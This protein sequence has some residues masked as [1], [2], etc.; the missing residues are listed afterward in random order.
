MQNS[1]KSAD[2]PRIPP[3]PRWARDR[4]VALSD[5]RIDGLRELPVR[6]IGDPEALRVSSEGG[7]EDLGP[8]VDQVP[9]ATVALALEG[10]ARGV[11]E[12]RGDS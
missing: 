7:P 9:M 6:I 8:A 2:E 5:R 12:A 11:M 4:L 1:P 10:M 3:L